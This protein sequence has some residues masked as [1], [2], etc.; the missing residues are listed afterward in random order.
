MALKFQLA[1]K[2]NPMSKDEKLWYGSVRHEEPTMSLD[3]LAEHMAE[4]NTP[5]SKGTIVGILTDMVSCIKEKTLEGRKVKIDN[6][7]IFSLQ[8]K[9]K[10]ESDPKQWTVQ[11]NITNVHLSSRA[12]GKFSIANL[13]EASLVES[14]DYSSPRRADE[15]GGSENAA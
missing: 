12:T 15:E 13:K 2:S 7:A 4:H 6:L 8:V 10:G 3:D 9:S 1:Q 14:P 11:K 5:Y